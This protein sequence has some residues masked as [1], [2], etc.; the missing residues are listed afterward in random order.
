MRS[1][2]HGR[3]HHATGRRNT[4]VDTR[5]AIDGDA[6]HHRVVVNRSK[7]ELVA[8]YGLVVAMVPTHELVR[9]SQIGGDY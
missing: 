3:C 2:L 6:A 7:R 4:R 9:L 1:V 8:G 5:R